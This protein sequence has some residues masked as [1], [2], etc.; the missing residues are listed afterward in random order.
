M[1]LDHNVVDIAQTENINSHDRRA[2]LCVDP[3][4]TAVARQRRDR[5]SGRFCSGRDVSTS[6]RDHSIEGPKSAAAIGAESLVRQGHSKPADRLGG[7]VRLRRRAQRLRSGLR[8]ASLVEELGPW[9][10]S[11]S[12]EEIVIAEI[13]AVENLSLDHSASWMPQVIAKFR[14]RIASHRLREVVRS[15]FSAQLRTLKAGWDQH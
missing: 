12:P 11:Q 6:A 1:G 2:K 4:M 15:S 3:T 5:T 14:R 10:G 7:H 8:S 13:V 9:I